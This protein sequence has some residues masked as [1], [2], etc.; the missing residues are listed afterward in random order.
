MNSS[1]LPDWK[2]IKFTYSAKISSCSC[3]IN[4][5]SGMRLINSDRTQRQLHDTICVVI[6]L[7]QNLR[8]TGC[9]YTR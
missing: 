3:H 1:Q 9:A 7:Y 8:H 5:W 2:S 4:N 6:L